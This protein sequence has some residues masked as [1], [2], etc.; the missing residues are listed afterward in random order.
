[1]WAILAPIFNALIAPITKALAFAAA[2]FTGRRQGRLEAE[3]RG[4]N[5][6]ARRTQE[7]NQARAGVAGDDDDALDQRLRR[8]NDRR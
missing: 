8:P 7:A 3:N 6:Q 5:E 4:L 1:M 2:F